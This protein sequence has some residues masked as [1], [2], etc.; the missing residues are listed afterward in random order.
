PPMIPRL[1]AL[2]TTV[3]MLTLY[4][5]RRSTSTGSGIHGRRRRRR[6]FRN[7]LL[8]RRTALAKW[9]ATFSRGSLGFVVPVPGAEYSRLWNIR[10]PSSCSAVKYWRSM[11]WEALMTMTPPQSSRN[12]EKPETEL[13]SG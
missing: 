11:G 5:R 8:G 12:A 6:S 4:F 13:G 2:R 9:L 7:A 1:F 10:W 3:L